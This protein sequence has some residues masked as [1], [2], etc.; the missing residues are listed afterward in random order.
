MPLPDKDQAFQ[1]LAGPFFTYWPKIES[2][3]PEIESYC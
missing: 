1:S 2:I 3:W